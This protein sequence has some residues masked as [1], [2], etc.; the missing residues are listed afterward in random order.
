M[1]EEL[2]SS[3]LSRWVSWKE[4]RCRRS[5]VGVGAGAFTSEDGG[6]GGSWSEDGGGGGS[7]GV[8]ER[9]WNWVEA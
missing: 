8:V 5:G 9:M 2:V 3:F 7:W 4:S 6:G 1:D